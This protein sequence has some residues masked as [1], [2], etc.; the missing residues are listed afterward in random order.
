LISAVAILITLKAA[1]TTSAGRFSPFALSAL[2][3]QAPLDLIA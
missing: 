1:P 3:S 2:I